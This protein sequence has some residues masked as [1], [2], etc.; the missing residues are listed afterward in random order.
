MADET[1]RP[2]LEQGAIC[3]L[4]RV[5][6]ATGQ[7]RARGEEGQPGEQEHRSQDLKPFGKR[8]GDGQAG[9]IQE[10]AAC[11]AVNGESD[12]EDRRRSE[13]DHIDE[14]RF[15]RWLF[16]RILQR[17]GALGR[18]R[19]PLLPSDPSNQREAPPNAADRE[20]DRDEN[21]RK[22]RPPSLRIEVRRIYTCSALNSAKPLRA[23]ARS[24]QT[25]CPR[26]R[27]RCSPRWSCEASRTCSPTSR[28][29]FGSRNSIS[30]TGSRN[31]T[32]SPASPRCSRR[33]ARSS[34][35]P[36]SW[37]AACTTTSCPRAFARS[38]P[39]PSSTARTPRTS[40]RSAKACCR[41]SGS[42]RA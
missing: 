3:R 38:S 36:R 7:I 4:P 8:N 29:R 20:Q 14:F 15:P 26:T 11:E 24:A 13:L 27:T 9:S 10:R 37:G 23:V 12:R 5:H 25:A 35:C 6:V 31:N 34:T 40:R 39:G 32:W 2:L 1:V 42:T 22:H 18:R 16:L 28:P 19:E 33:T 21:H 17:I 41:P 30:P